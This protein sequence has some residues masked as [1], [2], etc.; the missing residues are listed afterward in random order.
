MSLKRLNKR[1]L[2]ILL[3]LIIVDLWLTHI[4]VS[5][6]TKTHG[7]CCLGFLSGNGEVLGS[8]FASRVQSMTIV[9]ELIVKFFQDIGIVILRTLS[10]SKCVFARC[11]H[12]PLYRFQT[13]L[14]FILWRVHEPPHVS[15]RLPWSFIHTDPH[16]PVSLLLTTRSLVQSPFC[17]DLLVQ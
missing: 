17:F 11:Q 12:H 15:I 9:V 5:A 7:A 13:V 2:R 16:A 3:L 6:R 1:R 4:H 10:A 8:G 14:L